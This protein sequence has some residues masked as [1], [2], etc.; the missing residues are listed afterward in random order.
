MHTYKLSI[1]DLSTSKYI[2]MHVT[3]YARK[4]MYTDFLTLMMGYNFR[5]LQHFAT[6]DS[7]AFFLAVM[8]NFFLL[9]QIKNLV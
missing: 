9:A 8:T 1:L 5:I 6:K 3:I 4:K 7:K 2:V